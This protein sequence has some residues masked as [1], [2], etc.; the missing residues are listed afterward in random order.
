MASDFS[1]LKV[2]DVVTR[3]LGGKLAMKMKVVQVS[4]DLITCDAADGFE[5]GWTF[6]RKTGAEEDA[7]LQWGVRFGRTGSYLVKETVQ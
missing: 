5:G 3:L 7:D 2:G 6:D 4:E 1:D